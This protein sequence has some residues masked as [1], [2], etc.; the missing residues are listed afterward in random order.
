VRAAMGDQA[1]REGRFLG[2]RPPYGYQLADAGPHPNPGKAAAGQRAHRLEPDPVAAPIVV[3]IFAEYLTGRGLFAIAEGLTR[4]AVPS[5]SG[6]DRARNRHRE[7]RAWGKSAV[8]AILRNPRY[9]GHEV[10][11]KQ[12]RD[13]VLVDVEDV[14]AG[15][16]TRLRWNPKADWIWSAEVKHQ[17]VVSLDDFVR[18]QEQMAA[19]VNR[20]ATRKPRRSPRPYLLRGLLDCGI[21]GRRM[22]GHSLRDEVRYRCR[23]PT[24]YALANQIDHPRTVYVRQDP[25]IEALDRWLAQLFDPEHLDDT[26]TRLA[27]ASGPSEADEAAVDAARRTIAD[28]DQRLRR[29]RAALEQGADP[30]VVAAWIADVQGERLVAERLLAESRYRATT[31]ESIRAVLD[32]LSDIPT[33]LAHADATLKADVYADLGLRMIYQPA[34]ELVLVSASPCVPQRVSEGGLEPPR[35]EGH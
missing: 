10:W 21:C 19:G 3:R 13:E 14:A 4:D 7:G 32:Q 26:C 22:A 15:Y 17:P 34:E 16:Q 2:G 20:P 5:P 18:V 29:Y 9:T 12:R 31:P 23:Y 35:P 6:H 1:A 8:R 28:C 27:T 24:E 25:I 33:V 30:A 11:N